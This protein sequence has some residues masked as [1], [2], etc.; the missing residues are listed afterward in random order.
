MTVSSFERG[1]DAYASTIAKLRASL[2]AEGIVFIAYGEASMS[3]GA[4][5]RLRG[6]ARD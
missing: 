4:G 2:E 5:V 6:A 3:G 1:G